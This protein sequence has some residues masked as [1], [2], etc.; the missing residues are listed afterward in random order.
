MTAKRLSQVVTTSSPGRGVNI[1]EGIPQGLS[2]GQC[3]R[4][5]HLG[6][7][8]IK[9]ALEAGALA[10]WRLLSW[11][12]RRPQPPSRARWAHHPAPAPGEV[13]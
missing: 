5:L 10:G 7:E 4:A 12:G 8:T 2:V 9:R 11:R 13:R 3:A 6:E 1:P